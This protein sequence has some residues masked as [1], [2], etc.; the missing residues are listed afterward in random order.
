MLLYLLIFCSKVIENMLATL[1]L[2]VVANGKKVLGSILQGLVA[3]VWICVTGVVVTNIL[4]DPFKIIAFVLGSIVGSFLGSKLE[5]KIALGNVLLTI[6]V[7][8]NKSDILT[9]KLRKLNCAITTTLGKG[10]DN[11]KTIL[12]TLIPRKRVKE[13]IKI[14][15][16]ID[17]H[18][19]IISENAYNIYG[20]YIL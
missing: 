5:E 18:S 16:C 10:K 13:V 11:N 6:I 19:L 8:V 14:V 9:I 2:I 12:F 7:N 17:I 15:K 1:R 3:L 4:E 20:G